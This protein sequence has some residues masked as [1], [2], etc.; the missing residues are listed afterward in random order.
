MP[1]RCL[2][3]CGVSESRMTHPALHREKT[4]MKSKLPRLPFFYGDVVI[5][6]QLDSD[7]FR[8]STPL[9]EVMV[10]INSTDSIDETGDWW[11]EIPPNWL[12]TNEEAKQVRQMARAAIAAWFG[13]KP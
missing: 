2:N 11:V 10:D 6:E 4:T 5:L 1:K 7:R 8:V 12:H 3:G 9:Q 13:Q